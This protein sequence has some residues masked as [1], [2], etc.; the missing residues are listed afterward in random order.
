[1][2]GNKVN[3]ETAILKTG[4]PDPFG[5]EVFKLYQNGQT[6]NAKLH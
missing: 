6:T 4:N 3:R 5:K 2:V 1:M